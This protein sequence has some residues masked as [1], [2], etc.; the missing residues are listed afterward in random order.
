MLVYSVYTI[1]P[2][3]HTH[4]QAAASGSNFSAVVELFCSALLLDRA[5]NAFFCFDVIASSLIFTFFCCLFSY[6][7]I[8]YIR[9][10][11]VLLI[12]SRAHVVLLVLFA[13]VVVVPFAFFS[14]PFQFHKFALTIHACCAVQRSR[15][16][17]FNLHLAYI[18]LQFSV[19]LLCR[20][21]DHVKN[22]YYLENEPVNASVCVCVWLR[23]HVIYTRCAFNY[24]YSWNS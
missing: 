19:L 2:D 15:V 5:K 18:I 14:R 3:S 1:H 17:A 8:Q 24:Y 20:H 23:E 21:C 4:T 12:F 10:F 6:S 13:V 22:V 9:T 7:F 11:D 16:H